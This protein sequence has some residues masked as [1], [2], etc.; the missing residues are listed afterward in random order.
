MKKNQ[1]WYAIF[2]KL[3]M[4]RKLLMIMQI[5]F[6]LLFAVLLQVSATSL[7]QKVVIKKNKLTYEQLFEEI[8]AQTGI[9]TLL[10]NREINLSDK[11]FINEKY[12]ELEDL[13]KVVTQDTELTFELIDDYIIIRPL[14]PEEKAVVQETGQ[15]EKKTLKGQVIDAETNEPLVGVNVYVKETTTGTITDIHGEF[16]L[17]V[18][19]DAQALAFSFIGFVRQE[20]PIADQSTF[21][22]VLKSEI[23]DID[24]VVVV[25]YGIVKKSDLT[26]SVTK[27]KAKELSAAPVARVDQALRGKTSGVQVVSNSGVPGGGASI[28]IRGGNSINASN[29]PLYVID[30]FIG[31]GDLNSINTADIE[32]IEILKDASSTAIYGARGANG[33]VLITTKSGQSG[34]SVMTVDAFQGIQ[35]LPK[36]IDF[37]S[38][39]E[40]AKYANDADKLNGKSPSFPDLS[41]VSN[42]NW[43]EEITQTGAIS[44]L[45][46]AFKGGSEKT[47]Y[48]FSANYF[49]QEGIIKNSG[50]ERLQTRLNLDTDLTS[51]LKFGAKMNLSRTNTQNSTI[52]LWN[53]LKEAVTL[54]PVYDENGEYNT[55]NPLS[56]QLFENPIAQSKLMKNNTYRTRL[57]TKYDLTAS[58]NNNLVFKTS[59]GADLNFIKQNQYAPGSLPRR[60]DLNKGGYGRIDVN[61]NYN[62]LNENTINYTKTIDQHRFSLLGGATYQHYESESVWGK[63]EGFN[64]DIFEYNNLETGDPELRKVDSDFKDW[65]IVSFLARVN[66]SIAD[67]YLFTLSA[68]QDGSSRLAKNEKWA[69]FPS[70]AFAWRLSEEDF[71]KNLNVFYNLKFRASYGRTGSQAIDIY[72]TL[73]TIGISN[74]WFNELENIG[75]SQGNLANNDLKWETTDQ[76]SIGFDA[77]FLGGRL[78]VETDYY[79]K[80]TKDLLL[81]LELPNTTGYSTRLDNIG[82][83]ENRGLELMISG[84][85]LKTNNFTWEASFNI[86]KNKNKVLDLGT[87]KGYRN[88]GSGARLIEGESAIVFYGAIY[89]GTWKSQQEIDS[90][91]DYMV[92]VK[93]GY[94]K[95]KDCN[96]NGKYDGLDDYA[97]LGSPEPDFYGG[98]SSNFEYKNFNLD[99]FF[100]YSYGNDILN[101]ETPKFFFGDFAANIYEECSDRW[102]E[103][104]PTSNIPRAGSQGVLDINSPAFS[105]S[106]HDG[107]FLRLQTL[108]F[109]YNLPV[110]NIQW[111]NKASIYFTG[112]N[113]FICTNYDHGFDPEVNAKGSGK[114][115][116]GYDGAVYPQNRTYTL[117]LNIE[118]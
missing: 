92:G 39:V 20:L 63:G 100:T 44:N 60:K 46:V 33:V 37:L 49:D 23:S 103:E 41:K 89:E 114:L 58:F 14:K 66:Y 36:T 57:L 48:Y 112:E 80:K 3:S 117:G 87:E 93:P 72:S 68:R 76:L 81:S 82:E 13:L 53:V 31:G 24:E 21:R 109:S 8:E 115:L 26:G 56:G 28:R 47:K 7:A 95:F 15:P 90:N 51:W 73:P 65:T 64:N 111:L 98:F 83:I 101:T 94:P 70:S 62:I 86:A 102:T 10:S 50:Y 34:E 69:F 118:F 54:L 71:I 38:G 85:V 91:P 32:S 99:L 27:I 43:Q 2:F 16:S 79:Y 4:P 45:N 40:R 55:Q 9:A 110:K 84:K 17:E 113:L 11:V 22:V 59:F 104:N 97:I 67:K 74:Y 107:S 18:S 12:F 19:P 105:V 29:E 5:S 108:K 106:V 6:I 88:L 25:G 35:K 116:R 77:S 42:T 52:S 78:N 1:K 61:N 30:G 96:K 75:Y